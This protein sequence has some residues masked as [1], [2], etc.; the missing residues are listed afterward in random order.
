MVADAGDIHFT[1]RYA[2]TAVDALFLLKLN[3]KHREAVE[4]AVYGAERTEET[5]EHAV[6]EHR[7]D[8]EA[9][10][11]SEFPCKERSERPEH[12]VVDGVHQHTDSTA[13]RSCGA[14]ILTE[15]GKGHVLHHIEQGN[16]ENEEHEDYVL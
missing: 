8:D 11:Q 10:H 14:Y 7:S 6:D 15:G 16:Y 13:Q 2:K 9:A 5:A 12:A 4:D 3:T 1:L